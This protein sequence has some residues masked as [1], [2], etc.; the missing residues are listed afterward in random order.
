MPARIHRSLWLHHRAIHRVTLTFY[1]WEPSG[2]S[3]DELC[4]CVELLRSHLMCPFLQTVMVGSQ[5][6]PL[7]DDQSE[8]C[9]SLASSSPPSAEDC[10]S[11][12]LSTV[13]S[14]KRYQCFCFVNS[15]ITCTLIKFS[16]AFQSY[17]NKVGLGSLALLSGELPL[18]EVPALPR[19]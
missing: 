1:R 8:T 14:H 6:R 9:T 7:R 5:W 11:Y 17:C 3:C 13:S 2:K 4:R 15:Y 10:C 18:A 19:W 16:H 12:L